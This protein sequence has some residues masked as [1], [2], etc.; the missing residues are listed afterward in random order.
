MNILSLL[1]PRRC[2]GCG[3]LGQYFCRECKLK[4]QPCEGQIC[5]VCERPAIGG[6]T[7]PRCQTRYALDGLTSFWPYQGL[8]KKAIKELKYRF[9]T[10]LA[11]ELVSLTE[12]TS[13][14][15]DMERGGVKNRILAPVPLHQKR[16]NW[17]GFNQAEILG[18]LFVGKLDAKFISDL[19]RRKRYTKPQVE[20]RG[21]ERK[22]NIKDAFVINPKYQLLIP[23][24]DIYV[25]DD[26]W[27]T[28][29]TL[30]T[31]GAVLKK[32]G[33]K[34]VWGLTLAR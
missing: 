15:P 21:D 8:V 20:L 13:M 30:R 24:I 31:C 26:V 11:S 14:P 34:W 10:D 12:T 9:I 2:L 3:K 17:R 16:Q 7:H 1:F 27:T 28:G 19:L 5:P 29:A 32:A 25:F 22:E 23:K 4:I 18:K 33:V 6:V